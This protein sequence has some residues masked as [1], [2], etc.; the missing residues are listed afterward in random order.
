[1]DAHRFEIQ[2][3]PGKT[4]DVMI[5]E[6]TPIQSTLDVS[7]D[8]TLEMMKVWVEAPEGTRELKDQ[9]KKLLAVHKTLVDLA[10]EQDSMR[11]RLADY[12]ERMDELHGQIVTLQAVKTGGELMGHLKT[13]MKDISQRVQGTTIDVVDQEEEIKLAPVPVQ[14][15]TR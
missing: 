2:I 15:A 5:A 8:I 12:R 7:A 4:Q 6:A 9:L 13:K 11:R 14:D 1:G 10:Q 3:P